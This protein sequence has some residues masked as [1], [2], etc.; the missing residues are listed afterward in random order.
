MLSIV[1][2]HKLNIPP[3]SC[4]FIFS[5]NY[6]LLPYGDRTVHQTT[7]SPSIAHLLQ[8]DSCTDIVSNWR[9]TVPPHWV[10][11]LQQKVM[12]PLLSFAFICSHIRSSG[13]CSDSFSL[14][15]NL[16]FC[17]DLWLEFG[18][19]IFSICFLSAF[20]ERTDLIIYDLKDCEKFQSSPSY[21]TLH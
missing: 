17:R 12:P 11:S 21:S 4:V 7:P 5:Y 20:A 8:I 19:R 13:L 3:H 10:D 16:C 15:E 18:I 9:A 14:L 1:L 2:F 6:S